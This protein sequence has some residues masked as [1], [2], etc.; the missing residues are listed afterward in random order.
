MSITH[1]KWAKPSGFQVGMHYH[2]ILK[3]C[4]LAFV[5]NYT[6]IMKSIYLFLFLLTIAISVSAQTASGSHFT[7]VQL[8]SIKATVDKKAAVF[9]KKLEVE[10]YESAGAQEFHVDTFKAEETARLKMDIAQSSAAMNAAMGEL[11]TD[12]DKILNK[13]YNRLLKQ[14]TPE[15]QKILIQAQ[16]A[17]LT[18]QTAE[19]NL[20]ETLMNPAYSG[21]GTFMSNIQVGM[22][23]ELMIHRTLEIGQYYIMVADVQEGGE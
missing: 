13:Y 21:G 15:D 6:S 22:V 14:L 16:R 11:Y 9:K 7:T 19:R 8:Q 3:I 12:Y 20:I 2:R 18:F 5:T 17:W 1:R 23:T 10:A 4:N